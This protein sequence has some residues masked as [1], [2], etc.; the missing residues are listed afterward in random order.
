MLA[1]KSHYHAISSDNLDYF[2]AKLMVLYATVVV[3]IAL[4]MCLIIA[5]CDPVAVL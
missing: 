1:M 5:A 3:T 2:C 4:F